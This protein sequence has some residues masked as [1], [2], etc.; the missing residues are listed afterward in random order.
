MKTMKTCIVIPAYNEEKT[1][2]SVVS[3]ARKYGP[4]IVVDDC[5]KDR[6]AEL[7]R[8]SGAK[9][10]KNSRN[11]GTGGATLAGLNAAIDS[12]AGVIIT[13]DADGQHNPEEIPKFLA[14]I[15]EGYDFVLGKRN[16]RQYP[17][18]KK[19]G[20]F[21]LNLTTNLVSGTRLKD[22]ESG[23]RAF[24]RKALKKLYLR[25]Q[26]YE[27]SVE[28]AF[29]VGRN[30]LRYTNVEIESPLY[31]KGVGFRDGINNFRYLMQRRKRNW[32]SYVQDFKFVM[33]NML[34]SLF[35]K[36]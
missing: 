22:T 10:L 13:I 5:S 30:N 21:I 28:I 4:V 27:I 24:K 7:A 16:L 29:E 32:K 11:L 2:A 26:R 19:F 25:A 35:G 20:N 34:H 15:S 8:K 31:R 9:V 23:F 1:I 12:K 17:F 14:K 33:K 36:N 3:K 18:I 6:T